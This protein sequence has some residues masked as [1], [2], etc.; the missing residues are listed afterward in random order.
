MSLQEQLR[1]ACAGVWTVKGPMLIKVND[2]C[3]RLILC[4]L[5]ACRWSPQSSLYC[6][7]NTIPFRREGRA[8][9]Q[10]PCG[11]STVT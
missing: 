4:A 11:T 9:C 7:L 2:N 8:H 1:L 3:C 6:H 5:P 10:S